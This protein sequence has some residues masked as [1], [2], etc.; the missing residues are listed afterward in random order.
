MGEKGG[1][2]KSGEELQ[3]LSPD[4]FLREYLTGLSFGGECTWLSL[5]ERPERFAAAVPICAGDKLMDVPVTE[6]GKK[7]AKFPLWIFHGDADK[8]ISVEVSRKV[9]KALRDAGGTPK[10]TEYPGVGHNSWDSAYR[11]SKLIE[12]LFAQSRK[13]EDR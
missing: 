6:R 1:C 10:Y 2:I 9:V 4:P 12:W 3:K 8:V 13:L 11:D 5:M 7:F